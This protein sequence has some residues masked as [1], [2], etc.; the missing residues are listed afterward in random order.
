MEH[1]ILK[2]GI[3]FYYHVPSWARKAGC[4]INSE[5]LGMDYGKAVARAA[6][7][8]DQLDAWREEWRMNLDMVWRQNL[9]KSS[10]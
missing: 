5:A 2:N 3:G 6:E 4:P 10:S 9:S 8:N 1:R 7:L